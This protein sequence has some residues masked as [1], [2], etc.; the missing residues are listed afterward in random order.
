MLDSVEIQVDTS[1]GVVVPKGKKD[2]VTCKVELSESLTAPV[3]KGQKVGKVICSLEDEIL[4]EYPVT[5]K[6]DVEEITF[7]SVWDLL[8]RQFLQT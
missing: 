1:Q 6:G 4:A 5:A 7:G 3:K 8:I 2:Q